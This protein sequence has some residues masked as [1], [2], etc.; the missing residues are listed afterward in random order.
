MK[1]KKEILVL[2][3]LVFLTGCTAI[4]GLIPPKATVTNPIGPT[5]LQVQAEPYAGPKARIAVAKFTDKTGKGWW[6]GAIGDGMADM[7]STGLFQT[8]R[9]IV[10][11]RQIMEEIR[12]EHALGKEEIARKETALPG[13]LETAE[14][15]VTGAVTEFEPGA[16][17]LGGGIGGGRLG[18]I[19]GG[20]IGGI[21]KAHLAIDI[22]IV[23]TTTG[24]IVAAT[25]VKGEATDIGGSVGALA[26]ALTGVHLG[27]ALSGWQKTPIEAA[28]RVT[29]QE[30]INFVVSKTP[31]Q[32]YREGK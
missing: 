24:R 22:R 4:S 28:L 5:M 23:E 12:Q 31:S 32:Y 30:G 19:I 16:S 3:V 27:A 1:V 14:L 15:L 26:G 9:F 25:S 10:L 2:V 17:G 13:K 8:G 7:L 21:K 11:E 29:L 18:T 20:I 6:T